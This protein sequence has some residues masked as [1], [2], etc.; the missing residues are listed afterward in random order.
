[1]DFS[2]GQTSNSQRVRRIPWQRMK[3]LPHKIA[4]WNVRSLREPDKMHNLLQ[5]IE[6]MGANIM[7][8][9]Q[10][11]WSGIGTLKKDDLTNAIPAAKK[12]L[13]I[14]GMVWQ[15]VSIIPLN[16]H[17]YNSSPFRREW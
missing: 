2:P 10:M 15:S 5:E 8:I 11:C 4:T 12:C 1:M 17:C 6:R 16:K 13:D 3:Y 14:I 9:S 7:G